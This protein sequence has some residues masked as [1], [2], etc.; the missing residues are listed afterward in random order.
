MESKGGILAWET[1]NPEQIV[2]IISNKEL[3]VEADLSLE[4]S[5]LSNTN[6]RK[7]MIEFDMYRYAI[8]Y[9]IDNKYSPEQMSALVSILK[10]VHTCCYNT[11]YDNYTEAMRLFQ[12]LLKY[13]S[14]NQIPSSA[15]LFSAQQCSSLL[16][17]FTL[18]YFANFYLY[19]YVFT[20]KPSLTLRLLNIPFGDCVDVSPD[21][22]EK[23]GQIEDKSQEKSFSLTDL[24]L[25]ELPKGTNSH[26]ADN[27]DDFDLG[28]QSIM[29]VVSNVIT[30]SIAKVQQNI[31]EE[32]EKRED[33]IA[34]KLLALETSLHT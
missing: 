11:P 19:K 13:H 25:E 27:L 14:V 30:P 21:S 5:S 28:E 10:L 22:E 24:S 12:Q 33:I 8:N 15:A 32:M 3:A 16:D 18:T 1:L 4:T 29:R 6:A 34:K 7:S 31:L 26:Q 2:E 9:C 20:C 23:M 17:Y